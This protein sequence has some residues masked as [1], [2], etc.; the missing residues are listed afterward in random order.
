MHT[1]KTLCLKNKSIGF[2]IASTNFGCD[3]KT[4]KETSVD[5]P[6]WLQLEKG[7]P[8]IFRFSRHN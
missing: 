5:Y 7:L 6:K 3:N 1:E 2:L 8:D 4:Q